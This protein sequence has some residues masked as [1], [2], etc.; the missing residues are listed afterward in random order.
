MHKWEFV[1]RQVG[2]GCLSGE[3]QTGPREPEEWRLGENP[4]VVGRD[5]TRWRGRANCGRGSE[6]SNW[7]LVVS[8]VSR[9]FPSSGLLTS[10]GWAGIIG[11]QK[12]IAAA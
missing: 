4:E 5:G 12:G 10:R 9:D 7:N 6:F 8:S 1:T 3:P 11:G 2:P